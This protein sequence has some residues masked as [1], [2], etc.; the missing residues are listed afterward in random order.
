MI[1]DKPVKAICSCW[2][3]VGHDLPEP[4]VVGYYKQIDHDYI[5]EVKFVDHI[6]NTHIAESIQKDKWGFWV[7]G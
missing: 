1:L 7:L 3:I 2:D 5:A 4:F 6:G